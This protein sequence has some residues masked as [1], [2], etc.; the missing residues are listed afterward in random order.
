MRDAEQ[1]RFPSRI[2]IRAP[3]SLPHALAIAADQGMT[4]VSEYARRALVKQLRADGIDPM[5]LGS[6]M[7]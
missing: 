3:G 6:E 1:V 2:E 5:H 7:L 4:T